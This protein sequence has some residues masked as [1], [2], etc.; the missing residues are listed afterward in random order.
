MASDI[1][2]E[3]YSFK[4][5]NWM[6]DSV[7]DDKNMAIHQGRMLIASPHHMAVRV[8]EERYDP[9]SDQSASKIIYKE[10]KGEEEA[11][12]KKA[13]A[14]KSGK[15]AAGKKKKKKKKKK[16]SMLLLLLSVGG[17]GLGLLAL[18]GVMIAKFG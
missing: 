4:N 16:R 1:S 7:H 8:I 5:G 3:I 2:F 15:K 9:D 17:V 13:P 11:V 14:K 10:K 12:K 18:L 6:L